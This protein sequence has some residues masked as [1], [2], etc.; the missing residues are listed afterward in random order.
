MKKSDQYYAAMRA[1]LAFEALNE[2]E[3]LEILETLMEDKS[4]AV[5]REKMEAEKREKAEKE[6]QA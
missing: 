1:V 4:S 2:K 6:A 5:F 3:T